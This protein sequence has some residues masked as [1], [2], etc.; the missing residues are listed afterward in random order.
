MYAFEY[1]KPTSLKEAKAMLTEHPE[2][3]FLSGGHTLLPAMK[4]RLAGPAALIDLS[5]VDGMRGIDRK[6]DTLVIGAF[7]KHREVANSDVVKSAIPTLA[8]MVGTIGDP[9]V[10]HRGTIGGSIAN[11]DPSADYA[12]AAMALG[13]TI[14]TDSRRIPADDF[15]S[16]LFSTALDEGEIVTAVEFPIPKR[17]G[18]Q[19]FRNPASRYA[20]CGVAVAETASGEVRVS[21]IGAGAEGVFRVSA[22]ENALKANFSPDAIKDI[23]VPADAMASDIHADQDYRAH[24]VGVMARRAVAAAK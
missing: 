9:A 11:N 16:G 5:G 24:L 7:M 22:M 13:A 21:V 12:A 20:L 2:G 1:L 23:K 18:Y 15:F 14:V 10:R 4:L 17:M 8:E 19:K 3:K 6:G